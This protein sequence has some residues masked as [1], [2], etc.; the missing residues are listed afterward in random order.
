MELTT[1]TDAELQDL[2]NQI[3]DEWERRRASAVTDATVTEVITGLQDAGKLPAPIAGEDVDTAMQWV[4]PGTDHSS[5]YR[6]GV[7]V[8]HLGKTWLNDHPHLNHWEPGTLNG[9][10]VDVTPTPIDDETGEPQIIAWDIGQDVQP[11]DLRTHDG[12]TWE[13]LL[14]HT[15]HEGWVPG[16]ATHTVWKPVIP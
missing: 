1:L 2:G 9:G 3:G 4:D 12:Q 6:K 13:C 8:T 10:W 15:T 11:G 16:P 5:M 14:A 7:Y